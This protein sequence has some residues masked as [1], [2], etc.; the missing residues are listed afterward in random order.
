MWVALEPRLA[1]WTPWIALSLASA[2]ATLLGVATLARRLGGPPAAQALAAGFA[3]LGYA[4]FA[5]LMVAGRALGGEVRGLPEAARLLTR[6][7]DPALRAL[8]PGLLHVSLVFFADK[9]LVLTPF[10]SGLALFAAFVPVLLDLAERPGA[11]SAAA[12]AVVLAAALF[13]HTVVGLAAAL[14]AG[15]W[16]MWGLVRA[17]RGEAAPRRVLVPLAIAVAAA[18]VALAPY[19]LA[20]AGG[21]E[22]ALGNG[23]SLRA[24]ASG[25]IAGALF[26]P[27]GF[28]WLARAA[29]SPGP[30]RDLLPP[31]VALALLG[32]GLSLPENNQSKFWNLLFLLLAPPA[33]LAWHAGLSRARLALRGWAVAGLAAALVPTAAA[34]LV[35]FAC[36]RGQSEERTHFPSPGARAAWDWALAHTA[37]DA[38]FADRDGASDMLVLAGRSALWG[39]GAVERDWGHPAS[40][41]EVRRRA[42]RELGSGVE[43]SP[44]ARDL[45][46]A[47]RRDVIVVERVGGPRSG[48]GLTMQRAPGD[49]AGT[50]DASAGAGSTGGT[51]GKAPRLAPIFRNEALAL[52][53]WEGAP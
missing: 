12:L 21:K 24:L 15:A 49:S 13:T 36:E 44:G 47:L 35:G 2:F 14:L 30:A 7:A 9:F 20:V 3:V 51:F 23:L 53:R 41:L 33:A 22:R 26:V 8:D 45:L 18:G 32:L 37:K 43:L 6:G 28:A 27:A 11:R 52:Y 46:T 42:S 38:V 25:L 5:W 19:V 39:G 31:A 4:P 10:A 29:R 34:C 50:R 16:W 17:S 48:A 1:V 40:A